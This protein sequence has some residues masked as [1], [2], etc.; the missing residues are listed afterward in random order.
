[1]SE[2]GKGFIYNL[3]LFAKHFERRRNYRERKDDDRWAMFFSGAGDHLLELEIPEQ[4]KKTS[5]GSL[6]NS[7]QDRVLKYRLACREDY[8]TEE[9]F[10]NIYKDLQELA[11][12]IDKKL[13]IKTEVAEWD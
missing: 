1:M 7:I 2:Y 4:F 9:D 3:I 10:E 12:K 6:A 11:I 5:I 8:P 13:G